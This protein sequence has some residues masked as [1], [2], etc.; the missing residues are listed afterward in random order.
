MAHPAAPRTWAP[1]LALL[2]ALWALLVCYG[3]AAALVLVLGGFQGPRYASNLFAEYAGWALY[4]AMLLLRIR[5]SK[6]TSRTAPTS[7]LAPAV[8]VLLGLHVVSSFRLPSWFAAESSSQTV[9]RIAGSLSSTWE[10]LP[11]RA[12]SYVWA[13]WAVAHVGRQFATDALR[14]SPSLSAPLVRAAS[15]LVF[16]WIL[17]FGTLAVLGYATGSPWLFAE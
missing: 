2:E 1:A 7:W 6:L 3:A 16:T 9:S 13:V 17:G 11:L 14:Y 12:L 5:G 8:G 15:W 10:G 4:F